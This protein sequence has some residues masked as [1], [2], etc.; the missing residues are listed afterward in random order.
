MEKGNIVK[1]EITAIKP[2]GAFVKI[3]KDYVGLIHISDISWIKKVSHPS[4]IFKK[5]DK[6][7]A[8]VLSVDKESKKITSAPTNQNWISSIYHV[9]F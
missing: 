4:E 9:L 3:D 6:V 2:Y 8:I 5:G 7:D 1:G